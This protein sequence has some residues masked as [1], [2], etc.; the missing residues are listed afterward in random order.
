MFLCETDRSLMKTDG[1]CWFWFYVKSRFIYSSF[2]EE[3]PVSYQEHVMMPEP[4]YIT[5][6]V[7]V[8]CV[9]SKSTL[10][11]DGCVQKHKDLHSEVPNEGLVNDSLTSALFTLFKML[12]CGSDQETHTDFRLKDEHLTL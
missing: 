2:S 6:C 9:A 4:L 8:S 11:M 7:L 1:C 5:S 10:K 3:R 12:L